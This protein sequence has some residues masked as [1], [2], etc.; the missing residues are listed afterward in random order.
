MKLFKAVQ[1]MLER[2]F[3]LILPTFVSADFLPFC[4]IAFDPRATNPIARGKNCGNNFVEKVGTILWGK[5]GEKFW[6]CP[7]LETTMGELSNL[8]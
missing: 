5:S 4:N 2:K 8:L 1:K 6:H 3:K 7:A